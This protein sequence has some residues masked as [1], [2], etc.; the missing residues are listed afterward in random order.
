MVESQHYKTEVEKNYV[1]SI[2]QTDGNLKLIVQL[3]DSQVIVI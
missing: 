1:M 3:E 2:P